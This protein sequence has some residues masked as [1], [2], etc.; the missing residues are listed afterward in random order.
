MKEY[1]YWQR[2][3]E[4]MPREQLLAL[5]EYK[6]RHMMK[7][8]WD[9]SAFYRRK[10]QESGVC[11]QD[12]QTLEDLSLLPL[13]SKAE[14]RQNQIQ[15][16]EQDRAPYADV[17]CVPEE[18]V[19]VIISTAGTTGLPILMP[20]TAE[21]RYNTSLAFGHSALR[22]IYSMGVEKDDIFLYLYNMGGA[23]VGGGAGFITIGGCPP[24]PPIP[25]IPGHIGKSKLL[26]ETMRN[27]G[28]TWLYATPSF[29]LYLAELA[30]KNGLDPRKDFKL[31]KVR[32][33]GEPG[34]IAIPEMRGK[35]EEAWGAQCYDGWGQ[36]ETQTRAIECVEKC[37][38]HAMEDM[39]I[40]EVIDPETKKSLPPGE[41]GV[42]VVTSL[43]G[44]GSPLIRF[45]VNDLVRFD[46]GVCG[47]GRTSGRLTNIRGRTDDM[48]KVR[49][50]RFYP[51]EIQ[52]VIQ[53]VNGGTGRY[54]VIVD[55]DEAGRDTFTVRV[56][57]GR[58]ILDLKGFRRQVEV[59]VRN[60]IGLSPAVE[61]VPEGGLGRFAIK[62]TTILDF[63][64]PGAREAYE[65]KV[66]MSQAF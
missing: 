30:T 27:I 54:L 25:I 50:V 40:F 64:K 63:R 51:E 18:D 37:G 56:E 6:L 15:C 65:E 48:L 19:S 29:V 39:S 11:W 42:L 26:L 2:D 5:Q 1:Q 22:G 60:G 9:R 33:G 43:A 36:A 55:K 13:T 7:Y 17:L 41:M 20:F 12:I 52:K 35:I 23:I 44:N 46:Y 49:A 14:L 59:E 34:P 45:D 38:G 28:V 57:Y 31:R 61:L 4:T 66:K 16:V 24:N 62:A 10:F 21:D 8:V 32:V 58:N 3:L 47:C 53:G